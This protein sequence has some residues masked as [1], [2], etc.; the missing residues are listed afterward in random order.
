MSGT[1]VVM[2]ESTLPAE[3]TASDPGRAGHE[4]LARHAW[5]EAFELLS[6]ADREGRLSGS[7]L[8]A[9]AEASFF[10]ARADMEVQVKER[11]FKAHLDEGDRLRAAYVALNV[12]Q[13]YGFEGKHSIASAWTR[14]AERILQDQDESYVHGF[15]ALAQ[16]DVAKAAGDIDAALELAERA[17]QIGTRTG[18]ADLQA[19]S[20]IELGTLKIAIGETSQGLAF[21][22]EAS[23]A[24]VNGELSPITTGV[25]ACRM[26]AACR[27]LT[28]YRRAS[29]WTEATEQWCE[30]RSVSGFPGICRVHRAEVV[31]VSGAWRRAEEELQ[32]A[33]HELAGYNAVRPLADGFY[34]I[35]EIR[36]LKGDYE[37]AEA[38]LR[39]ANARGRT[40]HPALALIRL[41]EGKIK[42]A[43]ASI[44]SA[45]RD[46]TWDQWA[47]VRLLPAQVE[48]AVAADDLVHARE[49]ADEL[50]RIVATYHSPALEAGKHLAWGRVL[51]AEGDAMGAGREIRAS[52]KDWREVNAPYEVARGRAM[53]ARA[54][55]A[56]DDDDAAELELQAARD[57]FERLGAQPD[58]AAAERDA[59][60]AANR[61]TRPVPT[62]KT[63]MF[64]D[65]V[66]STNLADVLGDES[67]ER[68]LRWHDDM[69]RDLVARRRGEVV[70]STGD[71]FFVA[72]DSAKDGVDCALSIQRALADHRRTSGFA[73]P[74]RIGLHSAE[75]NRR[76]HDYS[77]VGVHVAARV[78]ALAGGG[79]ILATAETLAEA[80]DVTASEIRET[81]LKGVKAPVGVASVTWA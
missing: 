12:A 20:L 23:V 28:D 2:S 7:D 33:T 43:A 35:G 32:Q 61:R 66:G 18:N 73:L 13:R 10:A 54:L 14:R 72:F 52:I 71:G 40:P 79:E 51:L 62:R 9:L 69:L 22:E 50:A 4:A 39:E 3:P 27:D 76:E 30:R 8:E 21:M 65:I 58:V 53:L 37:G 5:Q 64:T 48:I 60:E 19:T 17:V 45:V 49:A 56:I 31:A 57:E 74:V 11:A 25:T 38:A 6:R 68:L 46:E 26:I 29:E 41:A 70:S 77:G 81:S 1:I 15:L 44:K 34:A 42:I 16:S 63:F 24:A 75:A 59:Q 55:R 47:R 67:W 78:A 36:R 80:G